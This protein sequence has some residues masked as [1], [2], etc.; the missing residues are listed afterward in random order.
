MLRVPSFV[1]VLLAVSPAALAQAPPAV[2]GGPP[3]PL[4]ARA[5][6][7]I[8]AEDAYPGGCVDCHVNMPEAGVDARL[9]TALARWREEVDADLLAQ[10]QSTMPE[11]VRLRGRHPPAGRSLEDVPAACLK[12][13]RADSKSAPA[14][15]RLLHLVHLTGGEENHFVTLFQ[16]ECTHCH[17]LDAATG[18]WSLPS[19]PQK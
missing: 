15:A 9:S 8:A 10:A 16:G 11:G 3:P 5:S 19:G 4:P 12:C 6:P 2:E 18:E 13:H 1:A 7:A 17:K 14:F